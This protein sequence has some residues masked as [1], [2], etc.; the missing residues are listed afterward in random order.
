MN[1]FDS[2]FKWFYHEE[3]YINIF[4][5]CIQHFDEIM[6]QV[7]YDL[8]DRV[9]LDSLEPEIALE[10]DEEEDQLKCSTWAQGRRKK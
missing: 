3:G 6:A 2:S 10:V 4:N 5:K 1:N 8:K 7:L 9:A